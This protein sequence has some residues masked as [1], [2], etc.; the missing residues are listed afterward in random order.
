MLFSVLSVYE[1]W[2]WTETQRDCFVRLFQ[3]R[4]LLLLWISSGVYKLFLLFQ[5]THTLL[6]SNIIQNTSV[7]RSDRPLPT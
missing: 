4:E 1:N 3:G 6:A 5:T 2:N 7:D